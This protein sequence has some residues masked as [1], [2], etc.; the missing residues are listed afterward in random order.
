MLTGQT[1]GF[2]TE[3]ASKERAKSPQKDIHTIVCGNIA[4]CLKEYFLQSQLRGMPILL[5]AEIGGISFF[6]SAKYGSDY[7][8]FRGDEKFEF[9][10]HEAVIIDGKSYY[11]S[12]TKRKLMGV[13]KKEK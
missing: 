5:P 13:F 10:K 9:E 2:L 3:L 6:V 4:L 1:L 11:P 12:K 7:R 8:V